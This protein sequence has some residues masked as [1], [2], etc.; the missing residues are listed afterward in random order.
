MSDNA[1][2]K[3]P[4]APK[5]SEILTEKHF[6]PDTIKAIKRILLIG[7]RVSEG[8]ALDGVPTVDQAYTILGKS[9]FRRAML[10]RVTK[11][12]RENNAR[13]WM[14]VP[15]EITSLLKLCDKEI[16][17]CTQLVY[18]IIYHQQKEEGSLD[19]KPVTPS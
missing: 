1:V 2:V 14:G 15:E 3:R 5:L 13:W 16:D 12:L 7:L 18:S 17:T 4:P 8:M 10:V 19:E 9:T 6:H 11:I